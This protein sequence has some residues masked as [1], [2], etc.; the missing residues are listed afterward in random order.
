VSRLP[1]DFRLLWLGETTSKLGTRIS[2]VALPL[3]AVSTLH[4]STF[5]IGL[6]T[7]APWLPWTLIGLFA[8]VCIDRLPRRAVMLACDALSMVAFGS[9]PVAW[10]LGVLTLPQLLVV[11]LLAG[12]ADVFFSTAYIV[13]LPAIVERDQLVAGNSRLQGTEQAAGLAGPGL[14]G[15]IV[16]AFGAT[17]GVLANAVSFLASAAALLAIRTCEI[18][19]PARTGP[20]SIRREVADGLRFVWHDPIVRVLTANAGIANLTMTAYGALQIVFLV[21]VL[22][23]SPGVVGGLLMALGA[24]GIVGALAAPALSRWLGT[25]RAAVA[26]IVCTAP[27]GLL[28]PLTQRGGGLTLFVIGTVLPGFGVLVY[29]VIV[30]SFRQRY[31]PPELLGRVTASMRCI[32]FGTIPVGAIAGGTLGT[33][34]GPRHALW[35][36]MLVG[37][38]PS[39]LLLS[40]PL[41]HIHELPEAPP[42][43]TRERISLI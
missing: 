10:W 2:N 43:H 23:L 25:A 40:S 12:A 32:V 7:A 28:I 18:R 4:A 35:V 20:R 33:A 8:G 6:L 41:R 29:N 38:V 11:A 3:V 13:Y 36:I 5:E 1:H 30:G 14:A 26:S 24:G 19:A 15:L 31:C 9:V 16:Q 27:F 39:A 17:L 22:H 34:I 21:R 42:K 37:L